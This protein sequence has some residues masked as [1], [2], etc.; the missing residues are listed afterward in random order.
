MQSDMDLILGAIKDSPRTKPVGRKVLQEFDSFGVCESENGPDA[1]SK[2]SSRIKRKEKSEKRRSLSASEWNS[3]D[4]LVYTQD[5]LKPYR[6]YLENNGSF[7][8]DMMSRVYDK[9]AQV[10]QDNMTNYILKEYLQWWVLLFGAGIRTHSIFVQT[11]GE[12]K[13]VAMFFKRYNESI[14]GGEKKSTTKAVERDDETLFRTGGLPML[15][16]SRGIVR[17]HVFLRGKNDDASFTKISKTLR[18]F[19]VS[20][21]KSTLD[22]TSN[23]APY[24]LGQ[25]VDFIS[26]A[27]PA[28]ELHGLKEYLALDYNKFFQE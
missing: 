28:L 7:G 8:A 19:S 6:V 24:P 2:M 3:K 10:F 15:L 9:L 12:E 17:S 13:Y 14:Y 21:L 27:R 20:V 25:K 16:M 1:L 23:G 26:I 22:I 11:I 4:F 5:L 18:T